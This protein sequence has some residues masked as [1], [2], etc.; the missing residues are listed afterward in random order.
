VWFKL[1]ILGVTYSPPLDDFLVLHLK[2]HNSINSEFEIPE[3]LMESLFDKISNES[4]LP[5]ITYRQ[6]F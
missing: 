1:Q 3:N 2:G 5:L 4:S 6:G